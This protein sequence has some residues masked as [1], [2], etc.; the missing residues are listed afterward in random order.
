MEL[1]MLLAASAA[2]STATGAVFLLVVRDTRRR[3]GVWGINLEIPNCPACG[4]KMPARRQPASFRQAVIGG[5]TC[6]KCGCEMDKW[7][8]ERTRR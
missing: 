7:G 5:W 6:P 4:L 8:A 1:L 3:R 2:I